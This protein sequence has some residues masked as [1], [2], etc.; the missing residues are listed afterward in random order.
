MLG[1]GLFLL[2]GLGLVLVRCRVS[3]RL[4]F[5]C[6]VRLLIVFRNMFRVRFRIVYF[7]KML[8]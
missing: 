7:R 8:S 6:R 4:R 5:V 2:I 1:L 3:F